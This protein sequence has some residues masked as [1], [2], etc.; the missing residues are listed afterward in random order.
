MLGH[1][2]NHLAVAGG[3]A[4]D[5]I[6]KR[7]ACTHPLPRGGTDCVQARMWIVEAKCL[8][9]L[10]TIRIDFNHVIMS[11]ILCATA[12]FLLFPN[13]LQLTAHSQFNDLNTL[14]P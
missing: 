13:L 7:C 9:V 2:Q 5:S 1:S 4:V 12:Y 10:K 14:M 3:Y 11:N 6:Q 8:F